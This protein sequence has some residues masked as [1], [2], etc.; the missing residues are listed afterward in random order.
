[1]F[2]KHRALF[3]ELYWPDLMK[4]FAQD[5]I[6][7]RGDGISF[8]MRARVVAVDKEGGRLENPRGEGNGIEV[9]SR[10]LGKTIT[11]APAVGPKNPKYTVRA[12]IIDDHA[13]SITSDDALYNF[14]PK[15]SDA[16]DVDVDE[17]VYVFFEDADRR[18]GVWDC[19]VTMAL[20][21]GD[22]NHVNGDD[23]MDSDAAN[24]DQ[25]KEKFPETA[26]KAASAKSVDYK[27]RRAIDGSV[28]DSQSKKNLKYENGI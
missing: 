7:M 1:M 14:W 3:P 20:G 27:S 4:R 12:R 9:F 26:G 15:H 5:R 21:V 13:N 11:Y 18:H 6:M 23:T 24:Q 2:D 22:V 17:Y 19:K 28:Q 25:L 10:A 16:P 8:L